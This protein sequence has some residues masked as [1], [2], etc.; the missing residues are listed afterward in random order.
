M[1]PEQFDNATRSVFAG[2]NRRLVVGRLVASVLAALGL[3]VATGES[4][5]RKRKKGCRGCPV[6]K[7][8]VRGRC[9]PLPDFTSCG[10]AC[11]ECQG[12]QCVDK[13]GDS[14]CDGNGRCL[15]GVCN[16]QPNCVSSGVG[17]C[18]APQ[19]E[20]CSGECDLSVG[21]GVCLD[22]AAGTPCKVN[23]DC[24]SGSCVGYV[25]E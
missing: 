6:C 24:T 17:G 18:S 20:C 25:C 3:V 5:A 21:G 2:Q 19:F 8:C 9:R 11:Q 7:K 16:P 4:G 23:G 14:V 1:D 22:G 13:S 12:G 10:G 15:A